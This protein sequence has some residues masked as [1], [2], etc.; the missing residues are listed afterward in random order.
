MIRTLSNVLPLIPVAAATVALLLFQTGCGPIGCFD[1]A[2]T[3]G[4]CPGPNEAIKQFGDPTCGGQ[5]KSVD[6][7]PMLRKDANTG[8]NMCCYAITNQE[9]VYTG[10]TCTDY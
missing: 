1:A 9:P 10:T 5:V 6:S 8:R 2:Q 7:E 3:N 4:T